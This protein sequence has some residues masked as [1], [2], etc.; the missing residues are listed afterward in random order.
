MGSKKKREKTIQDESLPR[1][2]K[3]CKPVQT[4][5]WASGGG[6]LTSLV[7]RERVL[8]TTRGGENAVIGKGQN[9]GGK[10][11]PKDLLD[12]ASQSSERL[13]RGGPLVWNRTRHPPD[14]KRS[15][16]E[17]KEGNFRRA[18]LN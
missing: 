6:P 18:S 9:G 16:D 10:D 4:R 11:G 5:R 13:Y 12:L 7:P 15:L 14:G 3:P 1:S 2:T 17:T 8:D